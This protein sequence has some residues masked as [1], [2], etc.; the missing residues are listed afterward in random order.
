LSG[1]D[2]DSPSWLLQFSP[3]ELFWDGS[4]IVHTVHLLYICYLIILILLCSTILFLIDYL[5]I[6]ANRWQYGLTS[7]WLLLESWKCIP[8]ILI[9]L[10]S[11]SNK[12]TIPVIIKYSQVNNHH[13][14]QDLPTS[15]FAYSFRRPITTIDL[16]GI[17]R[18]N[19]SDW[20]W[21]GQDRKGN[22]LSLSQDK[23]KDKR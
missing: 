15:I 2:L 3:W 23:L 16:A 9:P 22:I 5:S 14:S 20:G 1:L 11:T 17:Y 18:T 6:N 13:T 7:V 8:G 4:C 10:W 19:F 12:K 21:G